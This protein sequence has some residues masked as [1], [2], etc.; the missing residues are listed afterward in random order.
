MSGELFAGRYQI[1]RPLA[2]G[3]MAELLVAHLRGPGGF[4]KK[5]VIK[6][7]LAHYADDRRIVQLL[8]DEA[9]IAGSL[10]HAGLVSVIDAGIADGAPYLAMDLVEGWDLAQVCIRGIEL[11]RFLTL[12]QACAIV[13]EIADA[14]DYVHARTD[15]HGHARM[16]VHRDISPSNIMVGVDGH[17]RLVDFGIAR[18]EESRARSEA[19]RPGKYSYMAP[20]Q[21]RGEPV[22]SRTD[23]FCLGIVLYEIT[24]G[25]RLFK[26]RPEEAMIKVVEGTIP[27]PTFVRHDFPPALEQVVMKALERDPRDRFQTAGALRDAL[28]ELASIPPLRSWT[29]EIAAYMR[30]L[31]APD[32]VVGSE[33]EAQ[34]DAAH[35]FADE[36]EPSL[37]LERGLRVPSADEHEALEALAAHAADAERRE[38]DEGEQ[39]GSAL[40]AML[41]EAEGGTRLLT[42]VPPAEGEAAATDSGEYGRADALASR[43]TAPA[44]TD[45][46]TRD[47]E[48]ASGLLAMAR[49]AEGAADEHGYDE[50]VVEKEERRRRALAQAGGRRR[51]D[52]KLEVVAAP[53]DVPAEAAAALGGTAEA[54]PSGSGDKQSGG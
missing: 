34:I 41:L 31:L 9:R 2:M 36:G 44:P 49:L 38:T 4:V 13:A 28:G 11:G 54:P 45:D 26:G 48:S 10:G 46:L 22:D 5:V 12:G 6:R 30:F 8:L 35:D 17:A 15:D 3:G 16:I 39:I 29:P 21:I 43:L 51:T 24:V 40:L 7:L 18:D 33:T 42:Q 37:D 14:L 32:V 52:P 53:G 47:V 19:L 23:L 50:F 25:R 1:L 27:P 20:E